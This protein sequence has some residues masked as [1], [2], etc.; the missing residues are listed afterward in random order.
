MTAPPPLTDSAPAPAAADEAPTNPDRWPADLGALR[1]ELDRIDDAVHA[2]LVRRAGLIAAVAA[3][4]PA[5]GSGLRPGRQAAILRRLIARDGGAL[6]SQ[7]L[8]RI[9]TELLAATTAMQAPF[10]VAVCDP[11]PG[12]TYVQVAREQFGALTPLRAYGSPAQAIAELTAG[13]AAVAVLPLPSEAEPARDAWWTALMRRDPARLHI[14]AGLPLW[15]RR[16]E[17][18]P[19]APAFVLATIP[20]DPS[21]EDRALI[22]LELAPEISRARLAA[23]LAAA[24][25]TQPAATPG[26]TIPGCAIP[27]GMILR[28]EPGEAA[29]L[30]LIEVAGFVAEDDARLAAIEGALRPPAV[31]G[32]YAVPIEGPRS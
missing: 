4:K 2:L 10:I 17:G 20:P 15:A 26:G 27:G 14:V 7:G 8:V 22:G 19:D 3:T 25:F 23:S 29:A 11:A 28:R 18:A 24:G 31:L 9:W 21:G 13:R 12:A 1:A 6:P 32:C 5:G 16:P 30:A